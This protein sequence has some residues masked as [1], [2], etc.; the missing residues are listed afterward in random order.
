[1]RPRATS[2]PKRIQSS[3]GS[4]SAAIPPAIGAMESSRNIFIASGRKSVNKH[5]L[6]TLWR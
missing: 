1:M 4:L 6:N 5:G 3:I 2:T